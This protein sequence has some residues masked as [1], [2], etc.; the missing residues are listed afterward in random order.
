MNTDILNVRHEQRP[1]GKLWRNTT[2]AIGFLYDPEWTISGFAI[3]RSLPI[4]VRKFAPEQGAAWR[5]FANLLPEGAVRE[6]IVRDL[7]LPN[8]AW[9]SCIAYVSALRDSLH[10]RASLHQIPSAAEAGFQSVPQGEASCFAAAL[11]RFLVQ[12]PDNLINGN[13]GGQ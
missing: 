2:A 13:G 4:T 5:W 11:L 3:S 9:T 8:T 7:R 1:V 12:T 6:Q 10:G